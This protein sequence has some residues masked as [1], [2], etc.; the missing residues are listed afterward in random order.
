[1]ARR[2]ERP[3]FALSEPGA[4]PLVVAGEVDVLPAEWGEELNSSES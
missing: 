1:M 4:R 2:P 3:E